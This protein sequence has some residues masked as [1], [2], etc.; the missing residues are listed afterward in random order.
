MKKFSDL[1]SLGIQDF[2]KGLFVAVGGA[3]FAVI[4]SSLAAET[5]TLDWS[6]I[7]KIAAG[8]AVAYLGKQFFTGT[9]KVVEIDPAKTEVIEKKAE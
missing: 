6:N 9:P 5:F 3:V 1:F 8:A 7:A 2:V 4:Q